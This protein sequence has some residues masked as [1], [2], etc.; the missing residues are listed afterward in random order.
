MTDLS[1]TTVSSASVKFL[2]RV[3]LSL[4]IYFNFLNLIICLDLHREPGPF[5]WPSSGH[6]PAGPCLSCTV[7]ALFVS[8]L[9][10]EFC[11]FGGKN[12]V[13]NQNEA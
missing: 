3:K 13:Y 8:V 5:L 2:S 6:A 12:L 7:P 4:K 10:F 11:Y 9:L 1:V